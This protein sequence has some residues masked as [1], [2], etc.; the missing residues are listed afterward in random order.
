MIE[1][2]G[3]L[4]ETDFCASMEMMTLCNKNYYTFADSKKMAR[5]LAR[6]YSIAHC[7]HCSACQKKYLKINKKPKK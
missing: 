3:K 5:L 6:V 4:V 1:D 2:I 7:T